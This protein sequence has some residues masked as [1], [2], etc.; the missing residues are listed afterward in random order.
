MAVD[1]GD[2]IADPFRPTA[3]IVALLRLRADQLSGTGPRSRR[4]GRRPPGALRVLDC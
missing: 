1:S 4:L 3:A 2:T